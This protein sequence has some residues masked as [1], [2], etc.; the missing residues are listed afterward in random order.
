MPWEAGIRVRMGKNVTVLKK[1]V[2]LKLPIVDAIYLQTTRVRVV[3][4]SVQTITSKDSKTIS[5]MAT[6]S[7]SI[8][9]INKLYHT[10]YH[11]EMTISNIIMGAIAQYVAVN[12][13]SRCTPVMIE[14][15]VNSELSNNDYGLGDLSVKIVNYAVVRTY[16]LISNG[17]YMSEGIRLDIR[18]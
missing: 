18:A 12:E 14:S 13:F 7:Y 3:A 11:P 5:L 2:Y 10:L 17:D 9:D 6:C 15:E 4:L 8:K 16:R 1:G